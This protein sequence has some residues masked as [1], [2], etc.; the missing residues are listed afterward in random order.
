[1][2]AGALAGQSV[3]GPVLGYVVD[4]ASRL[5]PLYGMA[6]SA[7]IG[8]PVSEGARDSWGAL[9]LLADGTAM[10]GGQVLEGR[11]AKVQPGALLDESGQELLIAAEGR[12]PWR[13]TVAERALAV[14]VSDSGERVMTLLADGSLAGWN[15]TGQAEFRLA[16][17]ESWSF[18]FAGERAIGYDPAANALVWLDAGGN[19][20]LLRQLPGEGGKF[21]LGIERGGTRAVLLG[22][23]AIVVPLDGGE[24]RVVD[25]PAGADRLE[26][27]YGGR[28]FLLTRDP[29]QPLWV[30]DPAKED[31]LL[32]IPALEREKGGK[33]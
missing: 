18:A 3:G 10:R 29:A 9:I 8:A 27:V 28:A 21:A 33:Q 31:P 19:E 16:G 6:S 5:R 15:A 20:T 12:S 17:R 14:R 24:T 11:W 7:H 32:V 13:L 4:E 2:A 23:R 25:V 22:E 1:M 30:F 26:A